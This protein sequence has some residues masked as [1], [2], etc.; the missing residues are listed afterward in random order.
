MTKLR[1]I[2]GQNHAH[3]TTTI[4]P[5]AQTQATQ[6]CTWVLTVT[7]IITAPMQNHDLEN[8]D[9]KHSNKYKYNLLSFIS[10]LSR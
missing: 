10:Q 1:K 6:N 5:L 4:K 8:C 7:I 9:L 2:T 3:K